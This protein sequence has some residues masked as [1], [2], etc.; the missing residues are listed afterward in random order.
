MEDVY[1]LL[2][3]AVPMLAFAA[4]LYVVYRVARH[5]FWDGGG[6]R[7]APAGERRRSRFPLYMGT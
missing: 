5:G 4:L 1:G 2:I 7:G 6:N 3:I